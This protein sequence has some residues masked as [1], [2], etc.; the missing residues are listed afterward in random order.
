MGP[1]LRK[2]LTTLRRQNLMASLGVHWRTKNKSY[3]STWRS[4]PVFMLIVLGAVLV[5][6]T[7]IG[8]WILLSNLRDRAIAD[9]QRELQNITL[10]LAEQSDHAFQAIEL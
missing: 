5:L 4:R 8:T 7:V 3:F 10:I 9:S 6:S 2:L 1:W